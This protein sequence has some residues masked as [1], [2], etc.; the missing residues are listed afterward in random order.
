MRSRRTW[1][2]K[3]CRGHASGFA[4]AVRSEF[5]CPEWDVVLDKKGRQQHSTQTEQLETGDRGPGTA[6]RP[7]ERPWAAWEQ[8]KENVSN[9]LHMFLPFPPH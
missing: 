3:P 6:A 1:S 4:D 2:I 9:I 5:E 8:W 7:T